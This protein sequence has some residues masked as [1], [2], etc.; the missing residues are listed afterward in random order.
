MGFGG[1][2]LVGRGMLEVALQDV[3]RAE[4]G[5]GVNIRELIFDLI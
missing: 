1:Q 4:E 2:G 3:E 5:N